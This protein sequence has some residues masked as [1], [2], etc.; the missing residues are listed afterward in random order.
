MPDHGSAV[1]DFVLVAALLSLI[2]V[3]LVQL[4]V[5][6]HV[7]NTLIDCAADAARYG[8]LADRSPSDGVIRA[9]ALITEDLSARYALDVSA[10]REQLAGWTPW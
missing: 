5:V 4:A 7:R 1:V 9:R 3:G 6:L 8:A 10:D 2:F